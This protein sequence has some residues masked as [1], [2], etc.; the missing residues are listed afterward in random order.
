[1]AHIAKHKIYLVQ[2]DNYAL[3]QKPFIDS[4]INYR[5]NP[6]LD[7]LLLVRKAAEDHGFLTMIAEEYI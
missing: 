6:S 7:N 2:A 4:F 5:N 1:M 3:Y